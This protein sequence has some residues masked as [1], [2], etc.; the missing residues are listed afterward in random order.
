MTNIYNYTSQSVFQYVQDEMLVSS[1]IRTTY[2]RPF[3]GAIGGT[4]IRYTYHGSQIE[5]YKCSLLISSAISCFQGCANLKTIDYINIGGI[6][7]ASLLANMVK[8]CAALV[9][10]NLRYL[11]A[12]ISF[13]WSPLLSLAS[14]QYLI[15]YRANGTTPITITVH[16]TVFAKLTDNTNYPTWYAVNQDALTKYITFA[17]A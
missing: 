3:N 1:P 10:C 14:L 17:S 15:Q 4:S 8:D 16:P 12:N 5:V 2:N 11:K 9:T 7:N 13:Q 6:T